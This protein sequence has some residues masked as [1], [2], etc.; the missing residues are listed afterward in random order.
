MQRRIRATFACE[1]DVLVALRPQLEVP[2]VPVIKPGFIKK[3]ISDFRFLR[4]AGASHPVTVESQREPRLFRRSG[5]DALV[6]R[7]S[8]VL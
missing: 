5:G 2:L 1:C 8:Q 7:G 6:L 3:A 4:V